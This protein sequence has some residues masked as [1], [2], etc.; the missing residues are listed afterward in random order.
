MNN[1]ILNLFVIVGDSGEEKKKIYDTLKTWTPI[2]HESNHVTTIF[3]DLN[4]CIDTIGFLKENTKYR[5]WLHLAFKG[6]N[7]EDVI[8]IGIANFNLLQSRGIKSNLFTRENIGNMPGVVDTIKKHIPSFNEII[9]TFS[10][11]GIHQLNVEGVIENMTETIDKD[12]SLT[13]KIDTDIDYLVITAIPAEEEPLLRIFK[14]KVENINGFMS[15]KDLKL[16]SFI[17]SKGNKKTIALVNQEKMGMVD[18]AILTTQAIEILKPKNVIMTGVC[19]G[20]KDYD[21]G[22]VVIPAQAFTFQFG[23]LKGASTEDI[24][25]LPSIYTSSVGNINHI[26]SV[27]SGNNTTAL[28][29]IKKDIRNDETFLN[30]IDKYNS[31][32]DKK[33]EVYEEKGDLVNKSKLESK[34]INHQ[35]FMI[36]I[37]GDMACSTSVID[38]PDFFDEEIRKR[39]S[40]DTDAL[41]MESYGVIRACH[42]SLHPVKCCIIKSIMD[43]TEGKNDAY[44]EFAANTSAY[45]F[46]Y[47]VNEEII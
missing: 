8:P 26:K 47:L 44:K 39:F 41:E 5:V 40:R 10:S 23:K 28:K 6:Q 17:T 43:K 38:I 4:D 7:N 24:T 9:H 12:N 46:K 25:F 20:K 31:D 34:K 1:K 2:L 35:K 11:L 42:L 37:D 36:R 21:Y 29:E 22:D 27:F 13:N 32:L 15:G 33:I 16:R 14:D 19:G 30:S 3:S 45:T 18:A